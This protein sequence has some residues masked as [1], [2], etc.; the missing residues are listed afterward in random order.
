MTGSE[1]KCIIIA[2]GLGSRLADVTPSKPLLPV[3]GRPL[4]G[5]VMSSA[6][7]AGVRRFVVVTGYR[8]AEVEACVRGL[9]AENGLEVETVFN[10]DWRAENGISVARAEKLAGE[11]FFLSMSDHLFEPGNLDSLR[12]SGPEPGGLS[13]AVDRRV[14]QN[15]YIDDDDVTKVLSEDGLIRDIGKK[16]AR[17]NAYDTGLFLCTSGLFEALAA[18]RAEGDGSLSGGVKRLAAAG[19]ARTAD[20]G[21]RFWL[22][23]DDEKA[24][25]KARLAAGSDAAAVFDRFGPGTADAGRRDRERTVV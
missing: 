3:M 6:A 11:R 7:R 9:A 18:S 1:E 5:W 19:L 13:L 12:G 25:E 24:F 15:P 16:I 22:D 23:V 17:Y 14:G 8:A 21:K 20:I 2:A 10:E 4:I